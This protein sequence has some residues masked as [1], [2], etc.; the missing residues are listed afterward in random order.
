MVWG[1]FFR[2]LF[3]TSYFPSRARVRAGP[4]KPLNSVPFPREALL[5][6]LDYATIT[7]SDRNSS[8]DIVLLLK[9]IYGKI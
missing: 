4:A 2:L 6:A 5:S 8:T 1:V 7:P 9:G 3:D